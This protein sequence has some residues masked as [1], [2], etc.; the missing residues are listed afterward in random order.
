MANIKIIIIIILLLSS[1][2]LVIFNTNTNQS[3]S[4]IITP[5]IKTSVYGN[6]MYE[7]ASYK[8]FGNIFSIQTSQ[9]NITNNS[10]E[11]MSAGS[12]ISTLPTFTLH[13]ILPNAAIIEEQ[14]NVYGGQING[15][16]GIFVPN[17]YMQITA[18]A[19]INAIGSIFV[20]FTTIFDIENNTYFYDTLNTSEYSAKIVFL[21]EYN[22]ALFTFNAEDEILLNTVYVREFND[23][24]QTRPNYI[25][26][27]ASAFFL[28]GTGYI[29]PTYNIEMSYSIYNTL[30]TYDVSF[31]LNQSNTSSFY[32]LVNG[33]NFSSVKNKLVLSFPNGSYY[34]NIIIVKYKTINGTNI[35]Y[36]DKSVQGYFVVNANNLYINLITSYSLLTTSLIYSFIF[37]TIM[38][39]VILIIIKFS[40]G[41]FVPATLTA[42]IFLLM[43][44]ELNLQYFTNNIIASFML[45]IVGIFVYYA[46]LK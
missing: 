21:N 14:Q 11:T 25:L 40:D 6:I 45:L 20:N 12:Q 44:Y 27:N 10:A 46:V 5:L 38:A 15:V 29:I 34:Y 2:L 23:Y 41:N 3:H 13:T 9:Y 32:L 1:S 16:N 26:Y 31:Y 39:I 7:N 36:Y 4:T 24:I 28:K 30:Y 19:K 8:T 37:I 42:N 33:Y 35:T 22:T 17:I 18:Y 43:G